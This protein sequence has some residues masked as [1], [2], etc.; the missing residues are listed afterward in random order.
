MRRIPC[1]ERQG[2]RRVDELQPVD[3]R[4]SEIEIVVRDGDRRDDQ[5]G[6]AR[7]E[8]GFE[9]APFGRRRGE[10]AL[11]DD[12]DDGTEERDGDCRERVVRRRKHLADDVT[13]EGK[14]VRGPHEDAFQPRPCH[15]VREDDYLVRDQGQEGVQRQLADACRQF[16]VRPC[17]VPAEP[18]G[19]R[20][21]HQQPSAILWAASP[22]DQA[23]AQKGEPDRQLDG[24]RRHAVIVAPQGYPVN[25]CRFGI[26]S[27]CG[28][29]VRP[30][31][32]WVIHRSK[33]APQ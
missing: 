30:S 15:S 8:D 24:Q 6:W 26:S 5:D 7:P 13:A 33:G 4:A 1:Q 25:A 3:G 21:D 12:E 18:G 27:M 17:E 19:R 16:R 11:H 29:A 32:E 28:R 23:P 10:P 31:V 22:R 14:R 20:E 9:D 2:N